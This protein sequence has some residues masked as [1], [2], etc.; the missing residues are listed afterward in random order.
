[1]EKSIIRNEYDG[2][3]KPKTTIE[4]GQF[5]LDFAYSE[6]ASE[7]DSG[8]R[9]TIRGVKLSIL[10]LGVALYRMDVAGYFIDLGFRKFGEYIDKLAEDTGMNRSSLYNWEYIGEAYITHRT[11]LERIGF[12]DD[13]GPTKLPYLA[14]ALENRTK[15]EVFKNLV[16]MSKRDFIEWS[17]GTAQGTQNSYTN[18]K[19][20]GGQVYVG[21]EPL[22]VFSERLDPDD[23]GYYERV[24]MMAAEARENN[25]VVGVY[26]FYDESERR[27]FDKVYNR[28]LKAFRAKK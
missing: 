18:V 21:E 11:D 23:R 26:R 4:P 9:E 24:L 16:S 15:R 6:N 13:D 20:N 5:H 27:R 14:R 7:V 3:K 22:A 10:A 28:E 19:V 8:L 17:K 12:S 25:E 1:M 2:P